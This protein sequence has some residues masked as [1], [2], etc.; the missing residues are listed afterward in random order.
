MVDGVGVGVEV[1]VAVGDGVDEV[2]G[3]LEIVWVT[4]NTSGTT[5]VS[6][7]EGDTG[8]VMVREEVVSWTEVFWAKTT[9]ERQANMKMSMVQGQPRLFYY[10]FM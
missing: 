10:L 2:V 1:A 7:P 8:R 9:K 3:V 6:W 5:V 4:L